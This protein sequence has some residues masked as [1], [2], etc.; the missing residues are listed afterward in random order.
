MSVETFDK[1]LNDL[2]RIA[3][4]GSDQVVRASAVDFIS[5]LILE[6]RDIIKAE[7][8]KII[9]VKLINLLKAVGTQIKESLAAQISQCL[10]LQMKILKPYTKTVGV[11][12]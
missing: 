7:K 10:G 12:F 1:I 2:L 8:A 9:A 11:L 3:V 6:Q 4:Q 5:N